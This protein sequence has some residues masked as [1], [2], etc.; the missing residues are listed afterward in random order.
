MVFELR[1]YLASHIYTCL[2]T[3]FTFEHSGVLLNEYAE[4]AELSLAHNPRIFLRPCKYEDRSARAHIKKLVGILETPIV[5]TSNVKTTRKAEETKSAS[6]SRSS[7]NVDEAPKPSEQEDRL[8]QSY[9]EFMS[10]VKSTQSGV[11]IPPQPKV[12]Q[13]EA[14]RDLF[15]SA[16]SLGP[17][18][19]LNHLKCIESIEFNN[20]AS[21][22]EH[23][24]I[25]GDLFYLIVRTIENP[26]YE[27]G[28]TCSVNGFFRNDS[29]HSTF[30]PLPASKQSPCFSYSLF[31]CLH[32]LSPAFSRNL[33]TYLKSILDTEPFFITPTP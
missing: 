3:N 5:L 33:E 10:V 30:S 29:S 7:S 4:L 1:E 16:I 20:A 24:K 32:Q 31:G 21:V 27:H 8:K 9:E 28:I 18:K 14:L 11:P 12:Y 25:H 23:R 17:L 26:T 15:S 13:P 22:T 2:Y 19:K 6:R